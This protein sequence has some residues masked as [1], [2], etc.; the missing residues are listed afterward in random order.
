MLFI[1]SLLFWIG[2]T[3][4]TLI[5]TPVIPFLYPIPY[6]LRYRYAHQWTRFNLWWLQITCGLK[7]RVDGSENI[8]AGPCVIMSKHQSAWETMALQKMFPPQVWVMKREIFWIP[9][10]G[11]AIA[12]ME[13]IAID[14]ASG[15]KAMSQIIDQG[16]KTL[17]S[18]KW[19]VI[20]PEGT[21][22]PPG[23]KG[24]YGMGAAILATSSGYPVIPVALNSGEYWRRND[25]IKR[26]GTINVVIGKPI[27][28]TGRD[29]AE[30]NHEVEEW[31]ETQMKRIS[32]T[33]YTGE[34]HKRKSK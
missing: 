21:R 2:L 24:R 9:F 4:S 5:I 16:K 10:F 33:P 25:F 7:Y 8:P 18:G 30:L 20:F 27:D 17:D 26:P 29:P 15:R 32:I 1:R 22:V 11:W 13:P 19:V 34:L 6:S 14:R 31:I 28:S 12:A 3:L 23:K